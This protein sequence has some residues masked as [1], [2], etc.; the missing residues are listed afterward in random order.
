MA[1]NAAKAAKER[2]KELA[3]RSKEASRRRKQMLKESQL[4]DKAKEKKAKKKEAGAGG[5]KV[6][7][8]K[9]FPT[10]ASALKV[11]PADI[12]LDRQA[13]PKKEFQGRTPSV[14]LLPPEYTV[15]RA[16]AS[17][18]R[19][20]TIAGVGI[21]GALGVVYFAQGAITNLADQSLVAAQVQSVEATQRT[22]DFADV[23]AIY[24]ALGQRKGIIDGITLNSP[25]YFAA[26]SE[27]YRLAPSDSII[28]SVT[29]EH[30]SKKAP[31]DDAEEGNQPLADLCG[32]PVDPFRQDL[33]PVSACLSFSGTTSSV[34]GVYQLMEAYQ[35]STLFSNVVV[36]VSGG[37]DNDGRIT[38]IATGAVLAEADV[39]KLIGDVNSQYEGNVTF[40]DG[41]SGL[42]TELDPSLS[43]VSG[44]FSINDEYSLV[45]SNNNVI[46]EVTDYSISQGNISYVIFNDQNYPL[47]ASGI[48]KLQVL[49]GSSS[50][51]GLL[52]PVNPDDPSVNGYVID[53]VTSD[54]IDPFTEEVIAANG[55]WIYREES[56]VYL[57]QSTGQPLKMADV[58]YKSYQENQ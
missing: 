20:F 9:A 56:D 37:A 25:E 4:S 23:T 22:A 15:D 19:S 24:D 45:D 50:D 1:Q 27:L 31:V 54:I 58:Y 48:Q 32:P 33:R 51:E 46:A 35:S 55:T 16:V 41:D 52:E 39:T 28:T 2:R 8:A 44:S 34:N 21:V 47:D 3:K 36:E 49:F 6:A 42:D 12:E 5:I 38:F 17:M 30:I 26:L 18:R 11:K 29:I 57:I 43:Y 10:F 40:G 13:R 14:N 7:I 53:S